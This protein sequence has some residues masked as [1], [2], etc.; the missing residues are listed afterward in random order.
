LVTFAA[1]VCEFRL[2]WKSRFEV[3][4]GVASLNN[5]KTLFSPFF[6]NLRAPAFVVNP[7]AEYWAMSGIV[8]NLSAIMIPY[9]A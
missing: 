3:F 6:L 5:H 9:Y 1:L 7:S 8:D 2:F 4:D